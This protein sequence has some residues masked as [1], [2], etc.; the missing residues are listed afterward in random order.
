M[1]D[2]IIVPP[3]PAKSRSFSIYPPRTLELSQRFYKLD[4][5]TQTLP[6]KLDSG[7][8]K[9]CLQ[10]KSH[11]PLVAEH[12]PSTAIKPLRMLSPATT[13]ISTLSSTSK[14]CRLPMSLSRQVPE[15]TGTRTK[16]VRCCE[17]SPGRV[18]YATLADSRSRSVLGMLSGARLAQSIGMEQIMIATCVTRRP[19][20]AAVPGKKRSVIRNMQRNRG[21]NTDCLSPASSERK[22]RLFLI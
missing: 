10:C 18:R 2:D 5:I 21:E 22:S 13:C 8:P 7:N 11:A 17:L 3:S 9:Q 16:R 20:L 19:P 12:L 15:R 14:A 6:S 1:L 4:S